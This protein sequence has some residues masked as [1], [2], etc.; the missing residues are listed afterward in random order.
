LSKKVTTQDFI[1][2]SREV[3]GD[4]YDYSKS[5]YVAAIADITIICPIHGEFR[6]RPTNH[7]IGHGCH[8]CGGN[9]PL[10]V[11]RFIARARVRHG[12]RYDYSQVE[13]ENVESKVKIACPEH[14]VFVQRV[15]SHLKGFNCPRCGRVSVAG[16]L[17]HSLERFIQDAKNAHG[18]K[19]DY[20]EAEYVNAFKKVRIICPI[21]GTFLQTPASHIR[22]TGCSKCGDLSTAEKRRLTTEE[23]IARAK[24]AHGDK[25]DYSKVVYTSSH[26]KVEIVCA[27]HGS[28]FQSASNHTNG[29]K[30]GCPGCAVTGFDQT[31]PGL[32]YY[33][34]VLTDD[35]E[36]LYKIGITNLTVENRFPSA[37]LARI[38]VV[39]TWPFEIGAK[40]AER[41]I[42]I[43]RRFVDDRY[44]GR[45]VLVGA[46]NTELFVR[47]VLDLDPMAG[48][49][50]V[51]QWRQAQLF[52]DLPL[53][54]SAPGIRN[55]RRSRSR[56]LLKPPGQVSD[57]L[58]GL[59][60]VSGIGGAI[61]DKSDDA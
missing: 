47:D 31:K 15:M 35:G 28:F 49:Q 29:N 18:D 32:L 30:A 22:G 59:A 34:A 57:Q 56:E 24:L 6:Q 12:D 39:K 5:V 17:G 4:R 38:R 9:K 20:S 33:L 10:T 8:E 19:Y 36:T 51:K 43:L 27:E 2:R 40:A 55:R 14:G 48:V 13:F 16:K 11:E 53:P 21:H 3:H 61:V 41:E 52:D 58:D 7:Y 44:V 42:F 23:F 37:D 1:R 25:Y 50:I 54:S 26:D 46:G 45:D 60:E